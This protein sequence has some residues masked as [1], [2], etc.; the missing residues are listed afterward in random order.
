MAP[1]LPQ[2]QLRRRRLVCSRL[3]AVQLAQVAGGGQPPA[4]QPRHPPSSPPLDGAAGRYA[5]VRSALASPGRRRPRSRSRGSRPLLP[6]LDCAR[7]ESRTQRDR[8]HV[9]DRRYRRA[10]DADHRRA[11]RRSASARIDRLRRPQAAP[12][13]RPGRLPVHRDERSRH[14]LGNG[15][16]LGRI[17]GRSDAAIGSA[18]ADRLGRGADGVAFLGPVDRRRCGRRLPGL[19]RRPP[20]RVDRRSDAHVRAGGARARSDVRLRGAR[21]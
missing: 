20:G 8:R 14:R 4:V 1:L 19:P 21:G 13:P 6:A 15:P 3:R 2:L 9:A 18:G 7:C 10:R 12:L 11:R 17:V 16:V 5:L